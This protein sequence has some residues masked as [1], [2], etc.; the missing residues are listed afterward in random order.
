MKITT[1]YLKQVIK[2]EIEKA[3]EEAADP[4]FEFDVLI[5]TDKKYDDGEPV[6]NWGK[7]KIDGSN[8]EISSR[9]GTVKTLEKTFDNLM[10]LVRMGYRAEG[11]YD[12]SISGEWSQGVQDDDANKAAFKTAQGVL[13][14]IKHMEEAYPEAKDNKALEFLKKELSKVQRIYYV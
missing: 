14:L 3:L 5:D 12:N 7:A 8:I 10:E 13:R 6:R 1:T 2:E 9:C 11:A 4:N